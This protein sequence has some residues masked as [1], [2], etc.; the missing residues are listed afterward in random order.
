MKNFILEPGGKIVFGGGCVREYLASF[1]RKYGPNILLVS[2][3]RSGQKN[4]AYDE[5]FRSLRDAGKN[6]VELP[7]VQSGPEYEMV[8]RGAQ[9]ARE[10]HVDL[11]LGV[12]GGSVAD[13]CKAISM[14]AVCRGD[15]WADFWARQGVV[16]FQPLPVGLI[17]T[18]LGTG[19][20]NG[21]IVLTCRSCGARRAR[22]YPQ[23]SPQ[24][25][26][27]DPAYTETLPQT[28]IVSDG[29]RIFSRALELYLAP[30]A[31]ACVTDGLLESLM[32]NV[33]RE[34]QAGRAEGWSNPVRGNLM[35]AGALVGDD[36][37]QA[38]K[39]CGYPCRQTALQL[40]ENTGRSFT[41]CLAVL[42][43]AAYRSAC[44]R[45][46]GKMARLADRVWG[47]A[48]D[49]RP[50]DARALAGAD[51]MEA[52]LRTLGLPT[53]PQELG[54]REPEAFEPLAEQAARAG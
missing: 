3:S 51:A 17:P 21:A 6:I 27:F 38:G 50:K 34:L 46:T 54:I 28:Q 11:I 1:A 5:V 36:L 10:Q 25:I 14:A 26:L 15:L 7:G 45:Q 41:D 49:S 2:G 29:F 44:G 9:L 20:L 16:D 33:I 8:Q 4:G 43:A 23:C 48:P 53:A 40:A 13:C 42:Q 22:N 19:E 32:W 39:R 35:W 31:E 47:I 52:F 24:F 18:T 30:P 12:G 37:L